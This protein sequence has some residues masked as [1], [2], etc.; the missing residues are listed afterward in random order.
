MKC[1]S[2][3]CHVTLLAILGLAATP[4]AAGA[5]VQF[6]APF[7]ASPTTRSPRGIAFGDFNED[8]RLDFAANVRSGNFTLRLG[9]GSYPT[10]ALTT[11]DHPASSSSAIVSGDLNHDGHLDLV[12]A[13]SSV[14]VP[15]SICVYLGTGKGTFGPRSD[16]SAASEGTDS[17]VLADFNEDGHLDVAASTVSSTPTA[18][19]CVWMGQGDGN[20]TGRIDLYNLGWPSGLVATDVDEDGHEDLV[21]TDNWW[22][23]NLLCILP[24]HG[25]GTFAA[26]RPS[27]TGLYPVGLACGDLN[28]DG[29]VDCV[30]ANMDDDSITVDLGRGDGTFSPI[31]YP[32]GGRPC[33]VTIGDFDGDGDPD[34][35]VADNH[36]DTTA[37]GNAVTILMNTGT[38]HFTRFADLPVCRGPN[39]IHTGDL[40][41][42]D[43]PDLV[44]T[45]GQDWFL[46]TLLGNGDGTFNVPTFGVGMSP[47]GLAIGDLNQDGRGDVATVSQ[48]D[49]TL[50]VRLGLPKQMFAPTIDYPIQ[51][52]PGGV[53]TGDVNDDGFVDVVVASDGFVSVFPGDGAGHLGARSDFAVMARARSPILADLDQNGHLDAV[54]GHELSGFITIL[55]GMGAAGFAA[56][57]TLATPSAP[58]AARA[59]DFDGDGL[60]DLA[61]A[62]YGSS[63][64]SIFRNMGGGA[65]AAR[66][67]YASGPRPADLDTGDFDHDGKLDLAVVNKGG[68]AVAIYHGDGTGGFVRLANIPGLLYPGAVAV[69]DANHDGR[70]DLAVVSS[71]ASV[72]SIH[73]GNGDG[74]FGAGDY[75]GSGLFPRV[76]AV[77]D[78]NLD[79]EPDLAIPNFGNADSEGPTDFWPGSFAV[80]WNT[81]P[82]QVS[83]VALLS[84]NAMREA[85]GVR[86]NW[87]VAETCQFHLYQLFRCEPGGTRVAIAPAPVVE[88]SRYEL[89]DRD[90][91]AGSIDYWLRATGPGGV[92]NWSGPVNVIGA[93][94]AIQAL[95]LS[96]NPASG[97]VTLSFGLS[98]AAAV[99]IVVFDAAGRLVTR[100]VDQPILAGR[101]R[102]EWDLRAEDGRRVTS[103]IYFIRLMT[104]T[105]EASE[106]LMIVE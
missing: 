53:T 74:T 39:S 34:L 62:N 12:L 35:A 6:E 36:I 68:A 81:G 47:V 80:L 49:A 40:N 37:A 85:G 70:L 98:A 38:G 84:F 50:S 61:T 22:G 69:L 51:A 64:L 15:S 9:D 5:R 87:E 89:V 21:F 16:F 96:P 106:K 67:D 92:V 46:V 66:T 19:V 90:A 25:D 14:D 105:S 27:E 1:L 76:V 32:V 71:T 82:P 95:T 42:D 26:P 45:C 28:E 57:V 4:L 43:H 59:A 20:L 48:H 102:L 30:T 7:F 23:A 100:V 65:F 24:G 60:L 52:R 97:R 41:A 88:G 3:P 83:A 73:Y 2:T 72:V 10:G 77:G 78:L 18:W 56:P 63:N 101:H 8:G 31:K 33:A 79:G 58:Y 55:W 75:Y 29:H 93:P 54:V 17:V 44:L 11:S 94:A 99:R 13:L 86:V 104:P 103:G 91:P